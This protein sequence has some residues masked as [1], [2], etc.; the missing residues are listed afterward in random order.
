MTEFFTQVHPRYRPC[1]YTD[2]VPSGLCFTDGHSSH[3]QGDAERSRNLPISMN[4]DRTSDKVAKCQV[5]FITFLVLPLFQ[6]LH[7]WSPSLEPLVT[8][9]EENRAH[10]AAL[11]EQEKAEVKPELK[12]TI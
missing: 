1:H 10:F 8:Q 2:R 9:L 4:C 3:T 11:A 5:G 7:L 6:A 12:Y